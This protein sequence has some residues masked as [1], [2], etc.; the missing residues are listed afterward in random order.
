MEK[1]KPATTPTP[2]PTDEQ[3]AAGLFEDDIVQR[4]LLEDPVAK[5]VSKNWRQIIGALIVA[6]VVWFGYTQFESAAVTRREA[7][8]DLYRKVREQYAAFTDARAS[9]LKETDAKKKEELVKSLQDSARKTAESVRALGDASYPYNEIGRIYQ[10]LLAILVPQDGAFTPNV[11]AARE[12]LQPLNWK[13][14]KAGSRE[15]FLAELRA[16]LLGRTLLD[17]KAGAAEGRELLKALAQNGSVVHASAAL[18]LSQIAVT[19]D[20]KKEARLLLDT[21]RSAHAELGE[22][23]DA[24]LQRYH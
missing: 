24:E 9:A 5:F 11:Q 2:T 4:T 18:T 20:E 6:L 14:Q 23:I 21:L 10:A 15:R 8:A 16:L 7:A 17:D 12:A 1:K 19:D 22:V 3:A 13:E